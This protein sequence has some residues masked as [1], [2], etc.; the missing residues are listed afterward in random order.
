MDN[1]IQLSIPETG[2]NINSSP[3]P[4]VALGVESIVTV[5]ALSGI[6]VV[7]IARDIASFTPVDC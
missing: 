2:L 5:W 1:G 7:G 4:L 6:S 3:L